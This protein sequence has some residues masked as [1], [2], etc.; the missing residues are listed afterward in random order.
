MNFL[1]VWSNFRQSIA[2]PILP[3]ANFLSPLHPP[4]KARAKPEVAVQGQGQRNI[5]KRVFV[6]SQEI[7]DLF[8]DAQCLIFWVSW[9]SLGHRGWGQ[10][11]WL[12]EF[13][14]K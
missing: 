2:L 5:Q 13:L 14:P 9:D 7:L 4:E 10:P 3:L 6:S 12:H 11:Q 8:C 1:F